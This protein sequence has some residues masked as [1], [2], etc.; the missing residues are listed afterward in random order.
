M[1]IK[2]Q[3]AAFFVL[4]LA[5]F[6][7]A[8]LSYFVLPD[9]FFNDTKIYIFDK[10]NEIGLKGSYPITIFFYNITG[11]K[12]LHFS[13]IGAIQYIVLII[14]LF[15]IGIPKHF[16]KITLKNI[17]VYIGFLILAIFISMP[18]KEFITF[19]FTALIVFLYSSKK[20]N[21][22]KTAFISFVWLV[23]FGYFFREYYFLVIIVALMLFVLNK[24]KFKNRKVL[25]IIFG[26]FFAISISLSY[27]VVKGVFL[28]QETREQLND[29]RKLQGAEAMNSAII[30]PVKT[31]TWY[32]ESF[33]IVYGFFTVNLPYNSILSHVFSPQIIMFSFWQLFLF[34]IIYHRYGRCL[35]NKED[36]KYELWLF[37][38]LIAYFIIQGVFEPDL[39]SAIR[40]KAGVFPLIYYLMYHEEFRK[41]LR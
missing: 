36:N 3:N 29:F 18:T 40:H 26:L 37:Y 27:G 20:Y 15:K 35:N 2:K 24:I 14:I 10:Y 38:F 39:G 32:G 31:D 9:R 19:V 21:V 34:L 25:N 23:L 33:G 11:L 5:G 7:I 4:A 22:N 13:I 16:H 41:K 6:F 28:S 30:S 1:K 12:H 8:C 17:V